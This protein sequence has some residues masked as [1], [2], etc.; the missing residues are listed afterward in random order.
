[1][2]RRNAIFGEAGGQKPKG[3]QIGFSLECLDCGNKLGS[4]IGGFEIKMH[5]PV[6]L[7]VRNKKLNFQVPQFNPKLFIENVDWSKGAKCIKCGSTN[8][9]VNKFEKEL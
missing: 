1:M 9:R 5:Y 4:N 7:E 2:D 8:V 6:L 3:K